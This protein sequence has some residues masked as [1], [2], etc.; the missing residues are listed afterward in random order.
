MI[1]NLFKINSLQYTPQAYFWEILKVIQKTLIII[2]VNFYNQDDITKGCLIFFVVFIYSQFSLKYKPY[3][4]KS[5]NDLD[6]S[7]SIVCMSSVVLAVLASSNSKNADNLWIF[8][9]SLL[10]LFVIN[11]Y[12]I[13]IMVREIIIGQL[14]KLGNTGEAI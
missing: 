10:T 8:V 9:L 4:R 13:M 1:K 6:Y 7:V 5:L 14:Q 12:I 2:F 3:S 11:V